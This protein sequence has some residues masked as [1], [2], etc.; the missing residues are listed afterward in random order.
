MRLRHRRVLA[1]AGRDHQ[2]LGHR[3]IAPGTH[4]QL[5]HVVERRGIRPAGLHHRLDVVHV[6]PERRIGQPRLVAPHPV[7]VAA[8]RVDLAVMR[9]HAERLRQSPGREGVGRIALVIDGEA[10][11]EAR[12]EQ[13]RIEL[14]QALGQEHALVDDRARRQRA[15]IQFRDLRRDRLFL[16]APPHDVEVALELA[17]SDRFAFQIIICSISGRVALAFSPMQSTLIGTCRQP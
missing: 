2:R 16:D 9:E 11:D 3:R 14:R 4:Q 1:D 13:V 8:D 5:E 6:R 7:G 12:I 10:R 15:E 17:S